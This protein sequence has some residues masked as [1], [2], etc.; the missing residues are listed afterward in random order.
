MYAAEDHKGDV[1]G[2]QAVYDHD[3]DKLIRAA[4]SEHGKTLMMFD[5]AIKGGAQRAVGWQRR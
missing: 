2:V 1:I 5:L 4:F 3:S